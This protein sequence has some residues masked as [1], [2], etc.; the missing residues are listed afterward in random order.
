[1][2]SILTV[3]DLHVTF[4]SRFEEIH[5]VRGISYHLEEGEWLGII[6]ESG[7]GKSTSSKALLGLLADETVIKGKILFQDKQLN[8]CTES[9][10]RQ[11]RSKEIAFIPQD[12]MTALNPTMK[13]GLQ[14]LE[15]QKK[16]SPF[17]SFSQAEEA[18]RLLL[19]ELGLEF[20]SLK[21]AYPHMISGGMRQRTLIAIALIREPKMIIADEPT[22]ALDKKLKKIVLDGLKRRQQE[23]KLSLLLIS[24]DLESMAEY[25]DRILVMYAGK[26]VEYGDA[27]TIF[28]H[29]RH[30]YTK[31]LVNSLI[32][33]DQ[34][35]NKPLNFIKGQP[36][37]LNVPLNR[38]AFC[39]RCEEAMNV[40]AILS[41]PLY[42][43]NPLH[44]SA[45]FKHDPGDRA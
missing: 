26:I 32:K 3:Q 45:C 15:A 30:P 7:C 1:M 21:D 19:E 39:E 44:Q 20:D 16:S 10:I 38:C 40:C 24:H 22:T 11:I 42:Q 4:S 13:I 27:K 29:P 36:P 9:E 14:I 43:I 8:A 41:P 35:K 2:N 34:D 33:I 12:C 23:N 18:A 25:C 6:G 28:R 31:G 37:H 5:A 17:T